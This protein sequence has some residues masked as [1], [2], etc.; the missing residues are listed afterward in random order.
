MTAMPLQGT[1]EQ[2]TARALTDAALA[3]RLSMYR[4]NRRNFKRDQIDAFIEE[5]ERR[6]LWGRKAES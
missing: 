2:R 4:E 6:L 3:Q 1:P 5:A